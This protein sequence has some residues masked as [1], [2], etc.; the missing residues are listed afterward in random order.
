M[1]DPRKIEKLIYNFGSGDPAVPN[2]RAC[3]S[4]SREALREKVSPYVPFGGLELLGGPAHWLTGFCASQFGIA[5]TVVSCGELEI[6]QD[7]VSF[8]AMLSLEQCL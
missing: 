7:S 5:R 6:N 3:F 1:A 8:P 4:R 2:H